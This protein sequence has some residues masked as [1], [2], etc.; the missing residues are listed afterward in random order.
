MGKEFDDGVRYPNIHQLRT[1]CHY[2]K[3]TA[4]QTKPLSTKYMGEQKYGGNKA[5]EDP[6]VRDGSIPDTL[7]YNDSQRPLCGSLNYFSEDTLL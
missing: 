3:E 2:C 6:R 7:F 5:Q 1:H 4:G